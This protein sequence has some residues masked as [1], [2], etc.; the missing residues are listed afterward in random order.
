MAAPGVDP[1]AVPA[2]AITVNK[3]AACSGGTQLG[4]QTIAAATFVDGLKRVVQTKKEAEINGVHGAVVSGKVLYDALGRISEQG[5]PLPGGLNFEQRDDIAMR[6]ATKFFYDMLDRT[7]TVEAPDGAITRTAYDFG[8][9]PATGE[10][11]FRTVVVDPMGNVKQSYKDVHDRIH[12][13]T[14]FNKEKEQ[15]IAISTIYRYDALGQIR[16]ITDAR[17]NITTVAYDLLGRRLSITNPDTGQTIYT[18]DPNG[19]VT[20]KETAELRKGAKKIGYKYEFNR[21]KEI[22]YPDSP[23]V[24]YEYGA[25]DD[26]GDASG[27]LAGRIKKVTDESGEEERFYGRLGEVTKERRRVN[28]FNNPVAR[29]WFETRY[30]FDSFGRMD[31]MIYPDGETLTYTYDRGGLLKKAEGVKRGNRYVYVSKMTYDEFGQRARVEY[32]NGVFTTYA[33]DDKTRRLSHLNTT[34]LDQKGSR[35]IQNIDYTYDLVGNV[36]SVDNTKAPLPPGG[37]HGGPTWQDFTYDNLYQLVFAN[38]WHQTADNK[39]TTYTNNLYYDTIGNITNKVQIHKIVHGSL[40]STEPRETNYSMD[41][42]YTGSQPHAV[43]D[44]G[45]KLYTY[46]LNG[47]MRGWTS[48]TSGQNRTILWNEENRVKQISDSGSTVV[49]LYDDGGER[50]VKRGQHGESVYVNRFYSLKNGGLGSKHVFAGETRVVTKLEKDGGSTQTGVPGTIALI[51]SHG[52]YTAYTQGNGRHIGIERRLNPAAGTGA[53]NP[54]IEKFQFFYHGDHLGSSSFITDDAGAVYQHLE[55]FPYGET[56]V[57]EGGTGQ[58][59][60]YR[61][62]GKELDPETGLYYYGARYY[63]PVLSRWISADPI[64]NTIIGQ[65]DG[66]ARL[67]RKLAVYSYGQQNPIVMVDPNGLDDIFYDQMGKEIMR[68]E[69]TKWYN[70]FTWG[71]DN[72]YIQG[73][74]GKWWTTNENIE[75]HTQNGKKPLKGVEDAGVERKMNSWIGKQTTQSN[76]NL[77]GKDKVAAFNLALQNSP[78]NHP[79]DYKRKLDQNKMY[80]FEGKAYFRDYIGNAAWASVM[81]HV[82]FP[83]E[84]SIQAAGIVQGIQDFNNGQ[85]GNIISN[86]IWNPHGSLDDPRD[87]RAIEHGYRWHKP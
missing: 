19:N 32:G 61:F 33:Y 64:L 49:F 10:Y 58:M 53:T 29:T 27:N 78:Q 79:W 46:D 35:L 2:Y 77:Y 22:L 40:S 42:K 17:G 11:L 82:G 3:A 71:G 52:I 43:T 38:G 75:E 47:N 66:P 80:V 86:L 48:K 41:Y 50:A 6:N 18:Y 8:N 57:E 39:K 4:G 7:I 87:T 70:P 36:K 67:S 76:K 15:V 20:S 69:T 72:K 9:A 63:D 65:S 62:T 21:L 55:Y 1:F 14:E 12:A 59:P 37:Q 85:Y 5:Q 74:S 83:E 54:P 24:V 44:A 30:V 28:A 34:A 56:W 31:Q 68:N 45:D 73:K 13:V 26:A 51:N 81:E 25:K 16:S 23:H 60:Y 84:V